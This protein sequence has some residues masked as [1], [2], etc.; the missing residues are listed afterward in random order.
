MENNSAISSYR[1]QVNGVNICACGVSMFVAWPPPPQHQ[2]SIPNPQSQGVIFPMVEWAHSARLTIGKQTS[3]PHMK[4][5]ILLFL[6]SLIIALYTD[7]WGWAAGKE[8]H[9]K[10]KLKNY[11]VSAC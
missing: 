4:V 5:T 7:K 10:K 9:S 2:C 8:L 6:L 3:S 1:K 11:E